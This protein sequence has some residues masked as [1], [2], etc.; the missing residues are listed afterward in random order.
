MIVVVLVF[1]ICHV[2]AKVKSCAG[3][4]RPDRVELPSSELRHAG[5]LRPRAERRLRSAR[6][7]RQLPHLLRLPAPVST[8]FRRRSV[9]HAKNRPSGRLSHVTGSRRATGSNVL[10][11]AAQSEVDWLS[12]SSKCSRDRKSMSKVS[13]GTELAAGQDGRQSRVSEDEV[14]Q[15]QFSPPDINSLSVI[16]RVGLDANNSLWSQ[17]LR[18]SPPPEVFASFLRVFWNI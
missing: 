1:M 15:A 4:G 16:A 13:R 12:G 8:T 2:P 17:R 7:L 14:G 10:D 11:S 9:V 6:L 3:Q 5:V 18:L